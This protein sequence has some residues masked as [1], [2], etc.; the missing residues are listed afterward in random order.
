[1]I[2]MHVVKKNLGSF[3]QTEVYQIILE[4]DNHVRVSIMTYGGT[5]TEISLPDEKTGLQNIVL[6]LEKWKDYINNSIYLGANLGPNAGRIRNGYLMIGGKECNLSQNDGNHNLHGGFS[7]ASF[8]NWSIEKTE[9]HSEYVSLTLTTTLKDG[10]DGF[11]GERQ[12]TTTYQL[13]NS[14]RLT[15]EYKAVTDKDTYFNL[16]NHSYFNLSGDFSISGLKQ[17]LSIE[18]DSYVTNDEEYIPIRFSSVENS[19]YD[20]RKPIT[21]EEQIKNYPNIPELNYSKGYNNGFDIRNAASKGKPALTLWNNDKTKSLRMFT[22]APCVVIY[23]GG[24]IGSSTQLKGGTISSDSCAIALEAQDFPNTYELLNSSYHITG[25][26][27][28]Y[29]R[30]IAYEFHY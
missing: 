27:E 19:P 26:D 10:Q 22:D 9:E 5:I 28:T 18:A 14:D 29:Q 24:Y 3:E 1:M 2:Q 20:F 16:S 11:P 21:M 4:N 17:Y 15:L 8:A 30:K 13:D 12:I 7:P 6:S 25:K 23:S